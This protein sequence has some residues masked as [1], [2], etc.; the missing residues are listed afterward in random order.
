MPMTLR[1]LIETVSVQLS[2]VGLV[3]WTIRDLVGYVND[4]Q[5]DMQTMR[6]D[7]FVRNISH[8]LVTGYRQTIPADGT[9]L[10]KIHG[11]TAG[12]RRAVTKVDM[13]LLDQLM[14]DWR[15]MTP[16]V[17]IVHYMH[18]VRE[19]RVFDV[20]PPARL[21]AS[22][23]LEY[24]QRP[25]DFALP[26]PGT[27]PSALTGNLAVP[28]EQFTALQYYVLFRAFA[29]GTEE[30]HAAR[31]AAAYSMFKNEL[32]VDTQA[33]VAVAPTATT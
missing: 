8:P 27:L 17:E 7:L 4:G 9:H 1:S 31:S 33:A 22:L 16:M 14:R 20:Y 2:D 23:D 29:Q 18:D 10:M 19:R 21:G 12:K 5:R 15:S 26:A 3:A 30:G 25:T 32:G 6:P 13:A 24:S 28:D 11:N